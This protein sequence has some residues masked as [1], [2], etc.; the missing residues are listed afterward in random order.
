MDASFRHLCILCAMGLACA[1][2]V[3]GAEVYRCEV[4][5]SPV[6]TDKP[7]R[8]G[9]VPRALP[10]LGTIPP[11]ETA[12]LPPRHALTGAARSAREKSDAAWLK[13]HE[14]RRAQEARMSPAIA[15]GRVLKDM[16]PDQV[17]RALGGPDEVTRRAGS[18][19]WI[20]GSGKSRQV[21]LIEKGRVTR[22]S[23]RKP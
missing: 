14:A 18:E 17:R 2:T 10:P 11:A 16:T 7:C 19:E 12:K 4:K 13:Q 8:A 3:A 9:A 15:E 1:W 6:Y 21:V 5:G 20:Y 22:I 23:G